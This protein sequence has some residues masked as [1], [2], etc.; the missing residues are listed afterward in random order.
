MGRD[1]Y[2][3]VEAA[4]AVFD[5]AD[6]ILD[7]DIKKACFDGPDDYLSGTEISQPALLVTSIAILRAIEARSPDLVAAAQVTAGLSLGEY[8]ALVFAG[9]MAFEDAL[10][11]VA[12]RGR[13]MAE[14]GRANPGTMVSILGPRTSEVEAIAA[15]VQQQGV[16]RIANLNCPGQTVISGSVEL[17]RAAAEIAANELGARTVELK[18]AGAFH[19]E[20]MGQAQ[21]GL[22]KVLEGVCI[23]P[24]RVRFIS[25]VT[26]DYVDDPETIRALLVEQVASPVLW[27]AS[28]ER[29]VADGVIDFYEVGPGR[30]L[31][32]LIRKTARVAKPVS[33]NSV[34]TIGGN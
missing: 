2:G 15:R 28:V 29:M 22:C 17:V 14:A 5:A 1:F 10:R 19:T 4:R 32:G 16:C 20:L 8:T 26:A 11:V 34:D 30:V 24:P 18:V 13:L 6:E 33:V 12:E 3:H 25:N 9:A 23:S 7:I 27:Q 31:R 21:S